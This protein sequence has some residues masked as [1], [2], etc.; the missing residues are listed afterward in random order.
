[1][2]KL[3][4]KETDYILHVDEMMDEL[5]YEKNYGGELKRS[6]K[7]YRDLIKPLKAE[8]ANKLGPQAVKT[9]NKILEIYHDWELIKKYHS[10]DEEMFDLL[11]FIRM[12]MFPSPIRSNNQMDESPFGYIPVWNRE[13]PSSIDWVENGKRPYLEEVTQPAGEI[14]NDEDDF[15]LYPMQTPA[16]LPAA[17]RPSEMDE[18]YDDQQQE[19]KK[20]ELDHPRTRPTKDNVLQPDDWNA[21][22]DVGEGDEDDLDE[23]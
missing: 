12:K 1:M 22:T 4:K 14:A 5:K 10:H 19:D 18:R 17:I 11:S 9:Y 15:D 16:G 7:K 6:A 21:A 20:H 8:L 13:Y 23:E 2:R 3:S